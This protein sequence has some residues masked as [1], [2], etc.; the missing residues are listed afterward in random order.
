MQKK[1][2]CEIFSRIAGYFRPVQE[3]NIGKKEEFKDRKIF[4]LNKKIFN[5]EKLKK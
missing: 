2:S 3:W 4:K 1:I 5:I